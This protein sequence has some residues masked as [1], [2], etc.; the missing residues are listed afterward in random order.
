MKKDEK[1]AVGTSLAKCVGCLLWLALGVGASCGGGDGSRVTSVEYERLTVDEGLDGDVD[2][3]LTAVLAPY[4]ACV[5]SLMCP[6]VG[7]SASE[8][9]AY[10]PESELSNLLADILVDAAERIGQ[11]ADFG[12]YNMGGIRAALPKGTVTRGDV[13]DVAP[14]ENK[15]CIAT[16]SGEAVMQ[17]FENIA[18]SGG[19]GV[20]ASVRLQIGGD[21]TLKSALLRGEEI[22]P[23]AQYHVATLDYLAQGNDGLTAFKQATKLRTMDGDDYNVR[24]IIERYFIRAMESGEQVEGAVEGRITVR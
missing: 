12:I 5:D 24:Y 17:L 6:V 20:S 19:E 16:L 14:F 23:T 9:S 3:A 21:G 2:S 18:A 1:R 10:R 15:L 13:L 7:S 22:V 8:M 11:R 4:K